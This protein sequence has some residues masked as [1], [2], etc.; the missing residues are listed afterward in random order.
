[1]NPSHFLQLLPIDAP[2][3][4]GRIIHV[5]HQLPLEITYRGPQQDWSFLPRRGHSAMHAGIRSLNDQWKSLVIGGAGNIQISPEAISETVP[6]WS[7]QDKDR[8]ASQLL[9]KYNCI[10]LLLDSESAAGHYDGYCKTMLWPLFNYIIWNDATDGRLERQQ[11][12]AY[13]KVNQAYA[14]KLVEQYTEGDTIW[15]HDYHL[16]LVPVMVRNMLPNARI[17][18]FVHAS[19]PSSEIFRC[20]P[21][22][23]EI[24]KGMMGANLVG[25]QT[26]ANARHF[27]S[28]CTRVLGYESTPDGVDCDGHF[29]YVGTFPIGI[30]AE[31]IDA[32]RSSP[33]VLPKIKAIAEMYTG[34]KILV[35]R[36]KLDLVKEVLQKLSAFEKFLTDYPEWRNKVVLIQVTDST[37]AESAKLEHKV[38]EAAA[39]IN[40]TFGSLEFTPVHHYHHH[41]Q[42]DEYYALLSIAD[43]AVLTAARDG[44]NTTSLE[45]VMCQQDNHGPL[46]LS[47]LAGTAGSMGSA[48]MVNPWDYSGV[49]KAIN[50]ALVMSDEEKATRH[51]QLLS[52]VKSNTASFWA[53]SFVKS[54]NYTLA[55]S[56]LNNYTPLLNN[57]ALVASY[58][59][60]TKRLLCFD[61][62]GTVTPICKTPGA[63]VPPPDMLQ[64]LE[65]LC[66]D[67]K[68]EVW[69]I[70]GRDEA[71]LDNWLGHL[72][73]LGLS[74][75]HGSFI[76]YPH[77][78]KWINLAEHCDMNWKNDVLEIF[79]Y[80]TERTTGS[81]IEHK[82]CAITWHYRL[83]DP[84]Y[85]AFQAKECQNHL[86]GA[87][88]SKMP[89]EILVGKKN[90]EVRPISV[91]K[92]E[93]VNRLLV[94][95]QQEGGFDFC[96]SCG[97][98][99]TDEDMFKTMSKSDAIANQDVF[100]IKVGIEGKKTRA[101]WYLPTVKAV[102]Q[103][104]ESMA[105]ISAADSL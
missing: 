73:G 58:T 87:I 74:A 71:G 90:L 76:K 37:T 48:L 43:A 26:Y 23:Q 45:Y 10:P 83:A 66:A 96:L 75:E 32:Q 47:E 67:P 11:W 82:R 54:L 13:C 2:A 95:Q 19:F 49:A 57:E 78:S 77:T 41:I 56:E 28:T 35:G 81:F 50:D 59:K 38:S 97:D 89:V 36:D 34:K 40:G 25:F 86:E 39:H 14:D 15:V 61:Y 104:M 30:D 52:Q 102:I 68:N 12:D 92:G 27:I 46:I 33:G 84:D 99:R 60:A 63:A 3:E 53:H 100:S 88:L 80:Y 20:L 51:M 4:Q 5:C 42:R 17:G 69:I 8:L 105:K 16:L 70:S 31:S 6:P 103:T 64:A 62:D 55:L 85:G 21:K 72:P 1:M 44:M 65:I 98:D 29:C 24:L 101:R 9:E 7:G 22:R 93:V 94:Q 79:T 18:L 91:N